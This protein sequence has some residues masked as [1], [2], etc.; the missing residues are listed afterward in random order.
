MRDTKTIET[1]MVKNDIL[2]N[3]QIKRLIPSPAHY[4]ESFP[5]VNIK[6]QKLL[7]KTLG[8][9]YI[10]ILVQLE[11]DEFFSTEC[12]FLF[13]YFF[14]ADLISPKTSGHILIIS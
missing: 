4:S 7:I 10:T 2:T 13:W 1:Y 5:K 8:E 3:N 6:S 12:F 9:L 14:I 11:V